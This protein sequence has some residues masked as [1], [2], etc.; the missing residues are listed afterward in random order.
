MLT[1]KTRQEIAA[2]YASGEKLVVIAATYSVDVSTPA[3]IAEQFGIAQRRPKHKKVTAAMEAELRDFYLG[4]KK[5]MKIICAKFGISES[6]ASKVLERSGVK[7]WRRASLGTDV[8]L[9]MMEKRSR[10]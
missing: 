1:L 8:T 5:P 10:D 7:K 4:T 6:C 3:K 2:A 9:E